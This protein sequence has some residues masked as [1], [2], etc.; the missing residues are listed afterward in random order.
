MKGVLRMSEK[1]SGNPVYAGLL[2]VQRDLKA[3]KDMNNDFGKYKYRSAESILAAARPLCNDNGLILVMYDEV[4]L[5]GDRYYIRSIAKV[6]DVAT[7]TS[8]N[9]SAYAR[10]SLEKKGMDSSQLTGTASSYARK[11]ALC[12]LFAIDDN[13][14]ADTNEYHRQT[15]PES[16][17]ADARTKVGMDIKAIQ[18]A[19]GITNTQLEQIVK[20][21]FGKNC[22]DLNLKEM[23]ELQANLIAYAAEM[24][25]LKG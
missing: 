16:T 4:E 25:L 22:K 12:A 17:K 11:Y 2:A 5:I 10:E 21:Y 3:P 14:D 19:N 24:D 6:V 15:H 20:E 13:K 9:A 8:V 7:G 18:Q 1:N 23:Q